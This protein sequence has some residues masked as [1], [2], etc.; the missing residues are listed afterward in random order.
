MPLLLLDD[1]SPAV[2]VDCQ[3]MIKENYVQVVCEKNNF[4]I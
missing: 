4:N 2:Q 1:L 3:E